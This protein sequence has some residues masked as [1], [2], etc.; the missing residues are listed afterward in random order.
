MDTTSIQRP[1]PK[2]LG[3]V[4]T[5]VCR[6]REE[7]H[8]ERVLQAKMDEAWDSVLEAFKLGPTAIKLVNQH[9]S[10]YDAAECQLVTLRYK[11]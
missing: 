4:P 2:D 3:K 8:H 9:K 1:Q 11:V 6:I 10:T 5:L 7:G